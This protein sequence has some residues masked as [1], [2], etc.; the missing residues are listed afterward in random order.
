MHFF[1][2]KLL[3][4]QFGAVFVCIFEKKAVI[5]QPLCEVFQQ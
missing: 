2:K 1:Q 5:L 3:F 4:C